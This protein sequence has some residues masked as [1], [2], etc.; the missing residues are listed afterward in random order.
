MADREVLIM[1]VTQMLSGVCTAGLVHEPHP[2]SLLTW[3]RPVKEFGTLL[4]GDLTDIAGRLIAPGDVVALNLQQPRPEPPHAEDWTCDFVYRRPRLLR[5]LTGERRALFLSDHVDRA[6]AEVLGPDPSRSLCL[7]R[8]DRLWASFALDP[9]SGKYEARLG[10][11]VAG[12]THEAA[13]SPRG[14][15]VTDVR[16][17]ALGRAWLDEKGGRLSLR[18]EALAERLAAKEVYVA[19]GLSRTY[20]G[21]VWPLV[22]GVHTVPDYPTTV[23]VTNL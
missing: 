14:L 15:P 13:G 18:G 23:D 11:Q 7:L 16:W 4:V 3:V 2:S 9:Y 12:L 1:A 21:R 22:I 19:V 6:P 5:Q 20:Q 17:R 10:F 8:P